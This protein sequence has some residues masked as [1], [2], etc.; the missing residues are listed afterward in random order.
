MKKAIF[1][2]SLFMSTAVAILPVL[3]AAA[4][5]SSYSDED[6]SDSEGRANARVAAS[7]VLAEARPLFAQVKESGFVGEHMS[8]ILHLVGKHSPEGGKHWTFLEEYVEAALKGGHINLSRPVGD[9][10]DPF[11]NNTAEKAVCEKLGLLLDVRRNLAHPI[12]DEDRF[13]GLVEIYFAQ[14]AEDSMP[15][16]FYDELEA[17]IVAAYTRSPDELPI[18]DGKVDFG[19]FVTD[20][21][22]GLVTETTARNL[23]DSLSRDLQQ[24]LT[25]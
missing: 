23:A 17:G 14:Q 9:L 8:K 11:K 25:N 3:D 22:T 4:M 5:N 18:Q 6:K 21:Y 12:L 16:Y 19:Q 10:M 13:E 7:E 20:H 2:T 1:Y 15:A 24:L